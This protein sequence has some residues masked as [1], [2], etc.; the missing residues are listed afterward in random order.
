YLFLFIFFFYLF[1]IF[2]IYLYT[3]FLKFSSS[4]VSGYSGG[5]VLIKC[6]YDKDH[7][8]NPK[9]FCKDSIGCT[10][11]IS[12]EVKNEWVNKGRFSLIDKPSSAE[13]W[14]MIRELTVN[15]SGTYQC[16]VDIEWGIDNRAEMELKIHEGEQLPYLYSFTIK[17]VNYYVITVCNLP[18]YLPTV[19]PT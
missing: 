15:D 14:V 19:L 16:G 13:F 10:K 8:S 17:K 9:Y 11:Q 7:T 5:G 3:L 6:K 1:N 4:E 12:T 18:T 2:F